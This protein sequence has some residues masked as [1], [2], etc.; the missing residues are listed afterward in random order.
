MSYERA[1][2]V[3]SHLN[4]SN[5]KNKS[6]RI[7]IRRKQIAW[8]LFGLCSKMDYKLLFINIF[9]LVCLL[10]INASSDVYIFVDVV[11]NLNFENEQLQVWSLYLLFGVVNFTLFLTHLF[12]V[13]FNINQHNLN[14]QDQSSKWNLISS[15]LYCQHFNNETLKWIFPFMC[16]ITLLRY[17]VNEEKSTKC[18]MW[19]EMRMV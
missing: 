8:F 6:S 5:I 15:F 18:K 9:L 2:Q 16:K 12:G 3:D 17:T 19:V 11:L 1:S 7:G 4:I 13:K 10:D 14:Q